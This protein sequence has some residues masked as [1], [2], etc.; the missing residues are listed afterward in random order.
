[1]NR[2]YIEFKKQRDFGALLSD[3]FT[4]IRNEF[5]PLMK[6]IFSISGPALVFFVISM[7][8][9]TYFAGD[10]LSFDLYGSPELN[11]GNAVL[12]ILTAIVYLISAVLALIFV[13]S[14]TLHYIKSYSENSGEVIFE[15]VKR[16][17]SQ[18]FW[19][20]LGLGFLKYVSLGFALVLC[21]FPFLY[22][23]VPMFIVFCIYVFERKRGVT[24]SYSYS[25]SLINEDFWTSIGLI[26]VL[27][28][29]MYILSI[30][31]SI[32]TIIY[33]YA[34]MGIFSGEIDPSNLNSLNDPFYIFLNVISTLFS[35]L[36]NIVSIVA[37]ALV[38]FHLNEKRNFTGTYE[39][40]SN[41]GQIEE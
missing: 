23:M 2:P 7:A 31:F 6:T 1:M 30:V 35:I 40:I 22:V 12:T 37:S 17:V 41:I 10:L 24:D 3:T 33:T 34:K 26:I 16:N 11:S 38:Y 19:G 18:T 20:Y 15:D 14:S 8:F 9:Y 39:R 27:F 28:I 29:L 5:K 32:P 25:F 36:L 4:F 21:F 13:S